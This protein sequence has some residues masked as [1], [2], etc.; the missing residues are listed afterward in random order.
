MRRLILTSAGL[1][2]LGVVFLAIQFAYFLITPPSRIKMPKKVFIKRGATIDEISQQLH[3]KGLITSKSLFYT[4]LRISGAGKD[5]KAGEYLLNTKMPPVKI[6]NILTRGIVVTHSITIP[7]GFT[8]VQIAE[9]LQ[10]KGI[11]DGKEFIKLANDPK[12][13]K[14]YG[15]SAPSL[16]GY[17]YPDTYRFAS[18]LPPEQVIYAMVKRFKQITAPFR[19]RAKEIGMRFEDVI[20]L[21]SIVEK[22]TALESERPLIAS[23]FLNRLKKGLRLESDPT[24]IYGL[25]DF[26]GNLTKED[27]RKPTPYNTYVIHGLPPGAISNPGIRSIKAV[28]YPA[29]TDYLYFVSKNNGSHYFSKSLE[30]HN[31]A[32]YRYQKRPKKRGQKKP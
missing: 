18:G 28:L 3:E 6:I 14:R 32:V 17:L 4:W 21:A 26:S 30:E 15:I 22:E 23:V 27:L 9:L 2:F 16:E 12:T 1:V 8:I 29:D 24:T 10:E 25:M 5:I 7:E 11:T 20:T 13:A 19:E 31:R